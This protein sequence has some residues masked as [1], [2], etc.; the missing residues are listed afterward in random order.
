[1]PAQTSISL[2]IRVISFYKAF[3]SFLFSDTNS[4]KC[5]YPTIP[6]PTFPTSIF[7]ASNG[8][9]FDISSR[10]SRYSLRLFESTSA[11]KNASSIFIFRLPNFSFTPDEIFFR[12]DSVPLNELPLPPLE[13]TPFFIFFYILY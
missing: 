11:P 10:P 5:E 3:S 7:K 8:K 13:L 12:A 2:V 6:A 4:E 1:M 9:S